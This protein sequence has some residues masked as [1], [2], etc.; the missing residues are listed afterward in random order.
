MSRRVFVAFATAIALHFYAAGCVHQTRI[1]SFPPP[2]D[3]CP[4]EADLELI[5]VLLAD[6]A[7]RSTSEGYRVE[8]QA[9]GVRLADA[10]AY[11]AVAEELLP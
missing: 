3:P 9:V 4:T 8:L 10:S 2:L 5:G 7:K 11:C 1:S 6:A